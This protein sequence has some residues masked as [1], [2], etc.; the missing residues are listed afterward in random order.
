MMSELLAPVAKGGCGNVKGGRTG[1]PHPVDV[2]VGARVRMRRTIMG[3]SQE[4]LDEALGLTFQQVQKYERGVNRV[5]ASR[6]FEMSR[7]L[8]VPVT[9]FFEGFTGEARGGTG[10]A[11]E[12]STFSEAQE[13]S[14]R[15]ILEL[16]RAFDRI[17]DSRV[18]RRILELTK[19][20]G[21]EPTGEGGRSSTQLDAI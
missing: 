8:D 10:T 18:R 19:S 15:E 21:A 13:L 4:R 16:A 12:S 9:F 11:S 2:H 14:K 7:I 17:R 3:M 20:L 5:G 6:L 1:K